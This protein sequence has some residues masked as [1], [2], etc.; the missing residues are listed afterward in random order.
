MHNPQYAGRPDDRPWSDQHM[1]ILWAVMILAVLALAALAV[2]GLRSE[3][4]D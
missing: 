3:V 4:G 2:R 1:G